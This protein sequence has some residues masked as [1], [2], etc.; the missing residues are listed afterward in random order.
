MLQKRQFD[1]CKVFFGI[2]SG[3]IALIMKKKYGLPYLI[4]LGGGDI[5]GAQ[6]RFR[7]LYKVLKPFIRSVWK[8]ATCLVANS[9]DLQKKAYS[10]EERY[11]I[12]IVSNGVDCSFFS[13]QIE[14]NANGNN[15]KCKILFVSRLIEGKGLQFIIP[16]LK[17]I[18]EQ[19]SREIELIVV[20]DGP[21]RK[22]LEDIAKHYC[23]EEKGYS[24]LFHILS[25]LPSK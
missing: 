11:T 15:S 12:Q 14:R 17:Y 2:P 4:R 5:P 19:V 25:I 18:A 13:P 1:F 10:F 7:V 24:L 22:E 8:N 6:K 3:P 16:H 9:E 21:F 20:G 23:V